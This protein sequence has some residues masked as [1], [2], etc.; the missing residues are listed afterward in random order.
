[1]NRNNVFGGLALLAAGAAIGAGAMIS[2]AAMA[3]TGGS[4]PPTDQVTIVSIG[5]D[6][7]AVKCTFEGATA[8]DLLPQLSAGTPAAGDVRVESFEVPA[9]AR[10]SVNVV[11]V[12]VAGPSAAGEPSDSVGVPVQVV[13]TDDARE[14]TAQE[15]AAMRDQAEVMATRPPAEGGI[16]SVSGNTT[17]TGGSGVPS[18][19]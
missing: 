19:P 11:G 9:D 2:S 5:T 13:N 18:K 16:I 6:G 12:A 15:C 10:D 17:F 7:K 8:D 14:G 4:A 3:D 1:M